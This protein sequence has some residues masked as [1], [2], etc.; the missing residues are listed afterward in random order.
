MFQS[1]DIGK[2]IKHQNNLS[3]NHRIISHQIEIVSFESEEFCSLFLLSKPAALLGLRVSTL[4]ISEKRSS[5]ALR[6]VSTMSATDNQ[7]NSTN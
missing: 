2:G 6:N 4:L 3:A 5:I 1:Y 7:R